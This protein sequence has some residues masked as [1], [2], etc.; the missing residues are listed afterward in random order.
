MRC[1]EVTPRDAAL[2]ILDA[3]FG[4]DAGTVTTTLPLADY[5]RAAVAR[6]ESTMA[7][8]RGALLADAVGLGKTFVALAIIEQA[9][10]RQERVALV[11]PAALR[12]HWQ[13]H[14]GQLPRARRAGVTMLSHTELSFGRAPLADFGLVVVDEA[15]AFRNPNTRR[16]AGL[17]QLTRSSKVLLLTA[18][19]VNNRLDDLYHQI[20]LFAE[21]RDFVELGATS[22]RSAFKRAA[23]DPRSQHVVQ[24]VLDAI[25]VRRSREHVN[26]PSDE[27][28][29]P[30]R[31]PPISVRYDLLSAYG[32]AWPSVYHALQHLRFA[33]FNH[34]NV[35]GAAELMRLQ[36]LKR[37]ESS[38]IAFGT[39]VRRQLQIHRMLLGAL[40]SGHWI[41]PASLRGLID[42]DG[43]AQL[44][45]HSLLTEPA[46]RGC[47]AELRDSVRADR[48]LLEDCLQAL[49]ATLCI[50]DPKLARLESL[51]RG[52]RPVIVFTQY[53]DTAR[54]LWRRLVTHAR[55][56]LIHGSDASLGAQSAARST[57]IECFAPR[58]NRT[59]QPPERLRLDVLIATDVLSEGLNLQ[60]ASAVISYDLPWNPVTLMQR[61]GRID[62]LGS[63]H[64]SIAI[65]NFLP[66]RGLDVFLG[67]V[68][69]VEAKLHI[70][71]RTVGI[72]AVLTEVS[73]SQ[74]GQCT[75]VSDPLNHVA[76]RESLRA[77]W[78]SGEHEPMSTCVRA[79][80]QYPRPGWLVVVQ[81]GSRL[82][83]L[84]VD[85]HGVREDSEAFVNIIRVA[86][87]VHRSAPTDPEEPPLDHVHEW[88]LAE[89]KAK[90]LQS[91]AP[92]QDS[93]VRRVLSKVDA[94]ESNGVLK[95]TDRLL[96]KLRKP[97]TTDQIARLNSAMI[98]L[99]GGC[100]LRLLVSAFEGV[101]RQQAARKSKRIPRFR[102]VG[103]IRL[104]GRAG[105]G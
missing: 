51:L 59:R 68:K 93:A 27:L 73:S 87:D 67:L 72:D 5:Q 8:Y 104:G 57:V 41:R 39:S 80:M 64:E 43:G 22:L 76:Q 79:T 25:M 24:Q 23:T 2:A 65:Y 33:A 88:L 3:W 83:T 105:S 4:N 97:L 36:L 14:L 99:P 89:G 70:I 62:R 48:Q 17:C 29:F 58:A 45:L 82:R 86:L 9:L 50:E 7:R 95:R 1:R 13:R 91:S 21:G 26:P 15:H 31:A 81:H 34:T 10:H 66:D 46:P 52:V 28:R 61:I 18:T 16:Y 103:V 55:V 35:A 19:P 96:Q 44:T 63:P 71:G 69:R 56:G 85:E 37:L 20:A 78:L 92:V 6:I 54:Y 30:T 60:D 11:I 75:P 102:I 101:F 74:P 40:E 49:D 32:P 100:T 42:D 84:I 94:F 90:Q 77:R 47:I 38:V 12:S 98:S 53:R